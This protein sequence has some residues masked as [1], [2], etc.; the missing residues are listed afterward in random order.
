MPCIEEWLRDITDV[1]HE[2]HLQEKA[3]AWGSTHQKSPMQRTE[4]YP[5]TVKPLQNITVMSPNQY[6]QH[7]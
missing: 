2:I 4:A 6:K 7:L 3:D 5:D 1:F